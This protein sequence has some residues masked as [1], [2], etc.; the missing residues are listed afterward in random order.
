L[1]EIAHSVGGDRG[2][3]CGDN[4]AQL[5]RINVLYHEASG[6]KYAHRAVPMDLELGV[7]GAATQSRRSANSSA[8]TTS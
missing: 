5:D 8:R 7:I 3:Y 4:D 2:E 6:G 1:R